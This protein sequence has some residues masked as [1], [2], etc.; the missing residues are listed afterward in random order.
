M[1]YTE[2]QTQE[3]EVLQSIYPDELEIIT[4]NHFSILI[5]IDTPSERNH[6]ITLF[7][8]YPPTYPDTPPTLSLE[9]SSSTLD[10]DYPSSDDEQTI[11]T[12]KSL[13]I[14]ESVEFDREHLDELKS[15]LVSESESQLG[16]PMVFSLVSQLKDDS[17]SLFIKILN[18]KSDAY[19]KYREQQEKKDQLK[20]Q[21]TPVTKESF[22]KWRFSFREEIKIDD[23]LVKRFQKM[24]MGKLSGREIFEQGL[25]VEVD[26]E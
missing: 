7:V 19:N 15:N 20:F 1:D 23:I 18:Q 21:G 13:N 24:H 5:N 25:A 12:K 17:E 3:V 8:K 4:D 16:M 6:S 22:S 2:E 11:A 9:Y 26:E 14:A 10:I